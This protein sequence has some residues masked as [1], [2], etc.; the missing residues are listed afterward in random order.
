MSAGLELEGAPNFRCVA[1]QEAAVGARVR[2]GRLFRSGS[3]HALTEADLG[4]LDGLGIGL[5]CDLRGRRERTAWPDRW[6]RSGAL[7]RI[8]LDAPEHRAG[9]RGALQALLAD[10]TPARARSL[11]LESY[12]QFP[13][14]LAAALRATFA[15]LA[16]DDAALAGALVVHCA[17][18]KDRTGFAVA[19]ILSALGVSPAEILEDYLRTGVRVAL[20]RRIDDARAAVRAAA[21]AA[22]ADEVLAELAAVDPAL[23]EA[24]FAAVEEAHGTVDAYLAGP[25]GLERRAR[26]RVVER[27]TG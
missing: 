1:G 6:P 14:L 3:L 7:P 24:S 13:A 5:V 18:G 20:G 23:L 2:G 10:P 9:S 15:R 26:E 19:M 21:G 12:R 25:C 11:M 8:E 16:S 17:A 4:A 22:P 27:L